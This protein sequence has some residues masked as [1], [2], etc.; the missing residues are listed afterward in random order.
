MLHNT[1][2]RTH[3]SR[4]KLKEAP[5]ACCHYVLHVRHVLLVPY[6][7]L[8]LPASAMTF[9]VLLQPPYIRALFDH[10]LAYAT[11]P[12]ICPLSCLYSFPFSP[13]SPCSCRG[14]SCCL[15][16]TRLAK[17]AQSHSAPST[18]LHATQLVH[19]PRRSSTRMALTVHRRCDTPRR[20]EL[21]T[22]Q[23][24]MQLVAELDRGQ[25]EQGELV[26]YRIK[27]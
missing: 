8:T 10:Y 22:T 12:T 13:P 9:R 3:L 19:H 6:L 17:A 11:R 4:D 18:P 16:C 23:P 20:C 21:I 26:I 5:L 2:Y 25:V 14:Y 27:A 24:R 7:H 15:L 1:R